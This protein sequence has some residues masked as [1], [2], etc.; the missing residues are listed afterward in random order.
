MVLGLAY[1]SGVPWNESHF[2]DAEFDS[3]LTQAEGIADARER[4]KLIGKLETI[5][6][7]RGPVVQPIWLGRFTPWSKKVVGFNMHPTQYI[8]SHE[9]ALNS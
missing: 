7:E 5:M 6:Q 1:R 9:L 4:S 2:S 3:T 8:F